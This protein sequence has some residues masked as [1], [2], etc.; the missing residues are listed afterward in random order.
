MFALPP[1]FQAIGT[2]GDD[3]LANRIQNAAANFATL[4]RLHLPQ[5]Y[6]YLLARV[7]NVAE[8]QD[9]TSETFLAAMQAFPPYRA[10]RPFVAW[11][12][13]IARNKIADLFRR[14]HAHVIV[15]L[16]E[17]MADQSDGLEVQVNDRLTWS[18]IQ[19]Q[20]AYLSPDRAEAVS[21]RLF[22]GLGAAEIAGLMGKRETA[23]RMLIF[24]GMRD[25]QEQMSQTR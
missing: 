2:L 10:E 3:A 14:G 25:L 24:R 17:E 23:V 21:L 19:T 20:L 13:G 11:L 22:A 1:V 18:R 4:Y 9:L 7:G 8:A 5:V 16:T 12:L 6:R 15:V